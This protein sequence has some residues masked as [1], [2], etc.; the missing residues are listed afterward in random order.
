MNDWIQA[1]R[2]PAPELPA[3]RLTEPEM[4]EL[5]RLLAARDMLQEKLVTVE[6]R[7]E[8]F[9]LA[10]RDARGGCGPVKVNLE[11]GELAQG[12][13]GEELAEDQREDGSDE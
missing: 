12:Q 13:P 5:R 2:P 11:T 3:D 4:V 9:L 1:G 10:A 8:I 6:Q 7:L